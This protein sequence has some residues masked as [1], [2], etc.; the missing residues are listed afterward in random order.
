M[1]RAAEEAAPGPASGPDVRRRSRGAAPWLL[2]AGAAAA[3]A[4]L[5]AACGGREAGGGP[6]PDSVYVEAMARLVLLDTA[7]SPTLEPALEGS[8]R[9]SARS[10]VLERYGV[11]AEELLAFARERGGDP[12]R[13]QSVWQR[14]YELSGTLKEEDWRPLP[15]SLDPLAGDTLPGATPDTSPDAGTPGEADTITPR[16]PVPD[17]AAGGRS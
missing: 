7:V 3:L 6:V 14:V 4:L 1:R 9:D 13:M 12:E 17:T 15:D 11:D 16:N 8:A 10:R 2:T 5:A